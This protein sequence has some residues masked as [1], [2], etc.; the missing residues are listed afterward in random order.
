VTTLRQDTS[1]E[2]LDH[3]AERLDRL[4]QVWLASGARSFEVYRGEACVLRYGVPDIDGAGL[5]VPI[6]LPA[7]GSLALRLIGVGDEAVLR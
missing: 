4:A 1:V 6:V 2:L 3:Q 7:S 5:A